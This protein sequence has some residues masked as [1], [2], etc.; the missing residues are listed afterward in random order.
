MAID[1]CGC[2]SVGAFTIPCAN[3]RTVLPATPDP[4][5]AE[6]TRLR[7][8]LEAMT[9]RA[10]RAED[11][12]CKMCDGGGELHVG[13]SFPDDDGFTTCDTCDGT[14]ITPTAQQIAALRQDYWRVSG[15]ARVDAH[16]LEQ[17][18]EQL[19]TEVAARE[20][21]EARVAKL[22]EALRECWETWLVDKPELN[23]R[24]ATL[25]RDTDAPAE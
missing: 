2:T 21:A 1:A 18:R 5:D 15:D 10:E 16:D 17:C 3:H 14:G 7:A 19:A 8:D 20:R 6:I 22:R 9:E 23:S 13:S 11:Q 25:L 4:R 24:V 12:T